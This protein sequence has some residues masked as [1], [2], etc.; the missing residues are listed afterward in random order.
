VLEKS[1]L[2]RIFETKREEATE[3]EDN[4]TMRSS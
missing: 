1:V 4:F 2:R 3:S